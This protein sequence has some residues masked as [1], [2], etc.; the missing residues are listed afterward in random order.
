[1]RFRTAALS[2]ALVALWPAPSIAAAELGF[3]ALSDRPVALT[4]SELGGVVRRG[5][6]GDI[7]FFSVE[8]WTIHSVSEN[9]SSIRR[10]ALGPMPKDSSGVVD[11]MEDLV[12]DQSGRFFVPAIWTLRPR[13]GSAGVV[14]F[15]AAGRYERAIRLSPRT[16]VR[17]IAMGASG[18]LFILGIDPDY[19]RGLT[20]SCFLLHRY[21]ADGNRLSSFSSCPPET[22]LARVV[23]G[24]QWER[25]NLEVDRGAVWLD[26]AYVYHLLPVSHRI[27]VFEEATGRLVREMLLPPPGPAVPAGDELRS[28]GQLPL[29]WRA[30]PLSDGRFFVHWMVRSAASRGE[31]RS[32]VMAMHDAQGKEISAAQGLPWQ[33]A[34]PIVSNDDGTVTFLVRQPDN[35]VRV[36]RS[37]V[38]V[39]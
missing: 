7:F 26:G 15:G 39:E 1:M 28:V 34:V 25:L 20:N 29:V 21:T 14:V 10:I 23:S 9:D 24:P 33:K 16:N 12:V 2:L 37:E 3:R 31:T 30:L 35:T 36:I 27:R 8:R 32:A 19:F 6:R 22:S 38:S 11:L 13:G 5:P 17:H 18:D 4:P